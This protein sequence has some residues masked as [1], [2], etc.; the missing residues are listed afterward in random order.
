[1]LA[2]CAAGL[3]VV[4]LH[5]CSQ[6]IPGVPGD[7][8]GFD[9][10]PTFDGALDQP[11]ATVDH[12]SAEDGPG[13]DDRTSTDVSPEAL[14][15]TDAPTRCEES[16]SGLLDA[17]TK[18]PTTYARTAGGCMWRWDYS[19]TVTPPVHTAGAPMLVGDLRDVRSISRRNRL[20]VVAGTVAHHISL[21]SVS[22]PRMPDIP[23]A[24][25]VADSLGGM[26]AILSNRTVRCVGTFTY[27]GSITYAQPT[28]VDGVTTTLRIVGYSG[29]FLAP[30]ADGRV[31]VWGIDLRAREVPALAGASSIVAGDDYL[32]ALMRDGTVKC[33][34]SNEFR[35]VAPT[36]RATYPLDE[37]V[38][39]DGLTDIRQVAVANWGAAYALRADGRLLRWGRVRLNFMFSPLPFP[40]T[41]ELVPELTDVVRIAGGA[42]DL[43]AVRR[44]GS[45]RSLHSPSLD[46][47]PTLARVA[48]FGPP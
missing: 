47:V 20:C 43:L 44:D 17:I 8:G 6:T 22:D 34:G 18:W 30:L 12:G 2:S 11:D 10:E 9:R 41:P 28:Q 45:V 46:G 33:A 24:L 26:C 4:G 32:C 3:F 37:A 31:M 7:R 21:S 36:E 5:G 38:T 19:G 14:D 23:D 15:T 1:M 29:G 39:V 35:V 25:E 27:V 42:L 40:P 13:A 16:P 48:G